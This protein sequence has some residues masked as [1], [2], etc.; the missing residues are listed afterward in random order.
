ME[1]AEVIQEE[2]LNSQEQVHQIPEQHK[3]A[4][5]IQ[6]PIAT[7]EVHQILEIQATAGDK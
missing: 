2:I 1:M 3:Q 5:V 4:Q 7:L 6:L